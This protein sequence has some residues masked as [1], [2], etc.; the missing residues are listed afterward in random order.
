MT[1]K[2]P[3]S[4]SDRNEIFNVLNGV[5]YLLDARSYDQL[6]Q[7]FSKD[8][9]FENPG[10]LTADGLENVIN[11]MKKIANPAISHHVT[12]V[13]LAPGERQTVRATSK[14]LTIRADKSVAAAEYTDIVKKTDAGWRISSRMIRPLT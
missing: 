2:S 13:V 7:V 14:A 3:L 10:R 11:A 12:N 4:E 6:G 9:H 8:M 5:A 1:D